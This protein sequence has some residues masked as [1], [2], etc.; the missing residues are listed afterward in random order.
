MAF[1]IML[2]IRMNNKEKKQLQKYAEKNNSNMSEVI[3]K[4]ISELENYKTKSKESGKI[5]IQGQ[6]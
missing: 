4:F 1:E 6:D 2:R 5:Q 3:R